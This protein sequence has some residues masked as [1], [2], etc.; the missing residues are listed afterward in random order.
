MFK[1]LFVIAACFVLTAGMAY[2]NQ[3][4]GKYILS[5]HKTDPTNGKQMHTSYCAPCHGL[6]GRGGGPAAAMLKARPADLTSLTQDHRGKFPDSHVV[7]ILQFGGARQPNSQMPAWAPIL[8]K[9]NH[10]NVQETSLRMSNLSQYLKT[11]QTK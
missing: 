7:S 10:I 11:I 8:D 9:I 6:D 3:G 5:I 1:H 4:N 2:A